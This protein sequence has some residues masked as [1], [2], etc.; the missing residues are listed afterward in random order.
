MQQV[1][2]SRSAAPR[3]ALR[4]RSRRDL[5]F[6]RP[7]DGCNRRNGPERRQCR[8]HCRERIGRHPGIGFV[9]FFST[10]FAQVLMRPL[11]SRP[12][13]KRLPMTALFLLNRLNGSV[14]ARFRLNVL[15]LV[16]HRLGVYRPVVELHGLRRV[17]R[18]CKRMLH[19]VDIIALREILAR[20]CAAAFLA[21][22]APTTVT[23]A[24]AMR[25]SN[26]SVSQDPSSRSA[27]G[28]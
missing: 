23:A 10:D 24:C 25:L 4:S 16:G 13:H 6:S 8:Q 27:S 12:H 1:S 3:L 22:S 9:S 19:P 20:M 17:I 21:V 15:D 7:V 5:S 2:R 28:P 14:D 11:K 26:S 18:P